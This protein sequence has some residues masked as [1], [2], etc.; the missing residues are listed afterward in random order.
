MRVSTSFSSSRSCAFFGSIFFAVSWYFMMPRT[1]LHIAP[2]AFDDVCITSGVKSSSLRYAARR[3]AV[4]ALT[5]SLSKSVKRR[6]K[7]ESLATFF[8]PDQPT[9][10]SPSSVRTAA[11][12]VWTACGGFA[13]AFTSCTSA[14]VSPLS[15]CTA[16]SRAGVASLS[17]RSNS[18]TSDVRRCVAS[19]SAAFASSAIANSALSLGPQ[20][21]T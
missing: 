18:A 7:F 9:S 16:V 3:L 19:C 6:M 13:K 21:C 11:N 12:A 17:S 20:V 14:F 1:Q 8:A 5:L 2:A 4:F 10:R 15:A